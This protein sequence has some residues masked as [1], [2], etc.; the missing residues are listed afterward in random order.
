M[1]YP[2]FMTQLIEVFKENLLPI[3]DNKA[4]Y[5]TSY[6]AIKGINIL[7][8]A[9]IINIILPF[10]DIILSQV[11]TDQY[12]STTVQI[13]SSLNETIINDEGSQKISFSQFQTLPQN[14]NSSLFA[15]NSNIVKSKNDMIVDDGYAFRKK[16]SFKDRKKAYFVYY[17][18][19]VMFVYFR[20]LLLCCL[21]ILPKLV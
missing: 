6:G 13:N 16:I 3:K 10:L 8:P 17:A 19:K 2:K 1:K 4:R 15:D 7:G 14:I 18:L 5:L 9:H 21:I 11:F 12:I 20:N